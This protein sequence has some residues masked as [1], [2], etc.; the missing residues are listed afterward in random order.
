MI[1][2]AELSTG[3]ELVAREN[4]IGAQERVGLG[5]IQVMEIAR[6]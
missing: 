6:F 4:L 5:R 1:M 2:V 3:E